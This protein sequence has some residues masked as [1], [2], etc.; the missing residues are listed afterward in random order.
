MNRS[1]PFEVTAVGLTSSADNARDRRRDF[2]ALRKPSAMDGM[3][4]MSA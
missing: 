1:L 4:M 3:L 2:A